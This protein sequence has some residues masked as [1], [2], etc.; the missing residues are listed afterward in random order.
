MTD[1]DELDAA[2]KRHPSNAKRRPRPTLVK[3]Y[4]CCDHCGINFMI[5]SVCNTTPNSHI[6]PCNEP[7]CVE[8][9]QVV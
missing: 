6:V 2:V 8:G 9:T 7:G 5:D 1:D 4:R 3:N